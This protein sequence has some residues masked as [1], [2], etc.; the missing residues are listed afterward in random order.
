V[1]D[2]RVVPPSNRL[3]VSTIQEDFDNLVESVCNLL[4][5][6]W[7]A[8]K[9]NEHTPGIV[10]GNVRIA[11]TMYRAARFLAA[12]KPVDFSRKREYVLAVAPLGRSVADAFANLVFLFHD[13]DGLTWRYIRG[14]WREEFEHLQRNRARVEEDPE[15]SRYLDTLEARIDEL[16]LSLG[17]EEGQESKVPYWPILSQMKREPGLEGIRLDLLKFVD[18]WFYKNLSSESHLSG[19]GLYRRAQFLVKPQHQLRDNDLEELACGLDRIT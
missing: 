11:Y 8:G 9:G 14:G 1:V 12:E 3:D 13:L 16:R 5:R 2:R 10:W 18:D 19:P 7:P 17:I 4:E 6:E 15:Y